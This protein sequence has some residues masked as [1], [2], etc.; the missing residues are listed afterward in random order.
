MPESI[1]SQQAAIWAEGELPAAQPEP[2]AAEP[3]PQREPRLKP[4]NQIGRAHV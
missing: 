2:V 4:V 1:P 3:E